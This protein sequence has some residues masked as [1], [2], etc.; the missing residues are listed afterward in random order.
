M[1]QPQVGDLIEHVDDGQYF[2]GY[3]DEVLSSQ[4]TYKVAGIKRDGQYVRYTPPH[5]GSNRW[6][7]FCMY[8]DEWRVAR[9]NGR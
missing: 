5:G 6:T 3:V 9:P 1:N 2:Y 4:F 8:R 7:R